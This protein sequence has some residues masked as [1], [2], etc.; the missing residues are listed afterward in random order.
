M[1]WEKIGM[2]VLAAGILIFMGPRMLRA[3]KNS[4]KGTSEDWKGFLIPIAV[5]I[6]FVLLL[7][8]MVR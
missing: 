5:V 1:G 6:L 8:S 3:S 2:L 4:P 7:I